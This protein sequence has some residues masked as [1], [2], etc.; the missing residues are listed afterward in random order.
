MEPAS[1]CFSGELE[2]VKSKKLKTCAVYLSREEFY[3]IIRGVSRT[4]QALCLIG[5]E[6]V[7]GSEPDF[8]VHAF[9][10]HKEKFAKYRFRCSSFLDCSQWV[11]AIEAAAYPEAAQRNFAVL[12]NP[13]SGEKKGRKYYYKKLLPRLLLSP[14]SHSLF[15][16]DSSQFVDDWVNTTDVTHYTQIV[17]IGGDGLVNQLINAL[18]KKQ[19]LQSQIGVLPAGSQNALACALGCKN[20]NT[21][22]FYILKGFVVKSDLMQVTLDNK[23][24]LA[25]CALAWGVVS[26]IAEDAQKM[27]AFGTARYAISGAMKFFSPME[28]YTA[29]VFLTDED[30]QTEVINGPF[31]LVVGSNHAC[32]SSLSDEILAPLAEIDDGCIDIIVIK[33]AG[34]Y[35]LL[36]FL[37]K[38][39]SGGSHVF[40]S[41]LEYSKAKRLKIVSDLQMPLNVDGEVQYSSFI[42]VQVLPKAA[43]FSGVKFE[44]GERSPGS[45]SFLSNIFED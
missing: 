25:S 44:L 21:A 42:D 36:Q 11:I 4:I 19:G 23:Q 45:S 29:T 10:P 32:P 40:E 24:V 3:W 22:V 30:G 13:I 8:R 34:R 17:C 2:F 1:T 15:E 38:M 12:L 35:R 7:P 26:Q 37:T 14:T 16:T 28:D 5:A 6:I 43:N 41:W 33:E 18:H 20:I 27:R 9:K 31:V 39:R